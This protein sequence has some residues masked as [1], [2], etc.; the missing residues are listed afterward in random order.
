MANTGKTPF[1]KKKW[2]IAIVVVLILAAIGGGGGNS[3]DNTADVDSSAA[4][5]ETQ[6]AA[7]D[8][9]EE[10]GQDGAGQPSIELVAG[11]ENEYSSERTLNA[12][13]EFEETTLVY[14][15]PAGSYSV[16]NKGDYRTQVSVYE[17]VATNEDGWEE[18]ANVG[19]IILL[20][21]GQTGSITV[22]DGYYVDI[23]EPAHIELVLQ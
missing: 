11:V 10:Q 5:V 16:T 20:D 13:T 7:P 8:S 17:G 14:Y 18:P 12:G 6:T 1:W 22:P 9:E 15:V 4:Q 19:D 23:I 3:T 2:F 21:A